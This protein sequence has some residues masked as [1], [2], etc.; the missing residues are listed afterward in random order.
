MPLQTVIHVD[1]ILPFVVDYWYL[2]THIK[3]VLGSTPV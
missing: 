3:F 1:F 2:E